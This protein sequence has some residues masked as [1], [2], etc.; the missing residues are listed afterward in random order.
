MPVLRRADRTSIVT[1]KTLVTGDDDA[2]ARRTAG[3]GGHGH[4]PHRDGDRRHRARSPGHRGGRSPTGRSS[5]TPTTCVTAPPRSPSPTGATA[6]AEVLGVDADG[7]LAVLA[8]D[9]AGAT[10]V[11]WSTSAADAGGVVFAAARGR[12]G[13]RVTFGVV[14]GVDREFRGPRGRRITGSIE[15][16]APLARGSSGGPLV[17]AEG[18]LLGINTHRLGDGF[19]LAL[20]ADAGAARARRSAGRRP[21][22]DPSPPRH[23]RRPGARRP[24]PAPRRRPARAR[25]AARAR[26]RGRLAGRRRRHHD[27]RPH[28]LRRR[29]RRPAAPTTCGPSSTGSARRTPSTSASCAAPRS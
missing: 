3:C 12:H 19:Y 1:C 23:L 16:T 21:V 11:E 4:R 6:Q 7:D 15:H 10:P 25:R 8:V 13:L 24:P 2:S 28:R 20:P 22:A 9:T 27:G 17:D 18:R 26:R 29:P 5:P 14:S